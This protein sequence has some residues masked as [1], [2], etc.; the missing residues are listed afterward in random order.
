MKKQIRYQ[1]NLG[2]NLPLS[3][4]FYL[5]LLKEEIK[6]SKKLKGLNPSEFFLLSSLRTY[7]EVTFYELDKYLPFDRKFLHDKVNKLVE[8]N[9]VKKSLRA[10][11]AS[12]LS[13]F[14]EVREDINKII[15]EKVSL[16][17]EE[18][19]EERFRLLTELLNELNGALMSILGRPPYRELN[20]RY[21]EKWEV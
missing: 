13:I 17:C 7:E 5:E 18:M 3:N 11:G 14:P 15:K 4:K 8:L 12:L 16:I 2:T 21:I 1:Y 9:L 6:E 19:S 10:D 20:D